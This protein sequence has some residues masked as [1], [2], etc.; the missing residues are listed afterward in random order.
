MTSSST[1][2]TRPRLTMGLLQGAVLYGLNQSNTLN[3]WPATEPQWFGPL[4]M[5]AVFLPLLG[6]SAWGRMTSRGWLTWMAVA[7]GIVAALA[8][9]DLWRMNPL[10]E[11]WR[12]SQGPSRFPSF[13]A[14]V[15]MSAGLFMAHCLVLAS[16]HDGRRVASY[17]TCFDQAWKLGI[18][19]FFSALFVGALWLMLYLGASL[20]GLIGLDFLQELLRK[21]WF[22]L[23]VSTFAL[24]WAL[25]LTDVKPEIVRGIRGLVLVLLSWILPV[26]AA[27]ATGFLLSLPFT[28]LGLL[29]ATR[30]ATSVLM[31]T[32]AALVVL[33]NTA[34]Q[35]GERSEQVNRA[36]RACAR[37]GCVL[38][39]PLVGLAVY[40]L[41]LRVAQ[42]GWS[43][44]RII[45]C[46]CQLVAAC[47][48]LGYAWAAVSRTGVWLAPIAWVNVRV[49]WVMLATLL[50][51]FSPV[52]DPSRL[53]VAD[54]LDRLRDGRITADQLD[55]R[56]L[57]FETGRHGLEALYLL[58]EGRVG[59]AQAA[60]AARGA[61]RALQMKRY[62]AVSERENR[63]DL[64]MDAKAV[65]TNIKAVWPQGA[66]LP[67]T[68]V[69]TAWHLESRQGAYGSGIPSCL[70]KL[71][72]SCEAVLLQMDD[73]PALE[74]LIIQRLPQ[75]VA[76][77]FDQAADQSWQVAATLP[78]HL[79]SCEDHVE[80]LREGRFDLVAPRY[81]D[82]KLGELRVPL[83]R[84]GVIGRDADG[85][86]PAGC[87]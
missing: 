42:H 18:Q 87:R 50:A 39:L 86:L 30:H 16:A 4:L 22:N 85:A 78:S 37:L 25:H 33:I 8:W 80:R 82:L 1:D 36:V 24:A 70:R 20:F 7:A 71:E 79:A 9:Y 61:Q 52:A 84:D 60:S 31:I 59:G 55:Y 57:R 66:Q 63:S 64:T 35:N 13:H 43:V 5:L 44:D 46:A 6:I 19:H 41:G 75:S 2:T 3:L 40:A 53:A 14:W 26:V 45:A 81:K 76:V 69:Q 27:L 74:V 12:V 47:Y 23:L 51:L 17:A 38:L 83:R 48:A 72:A 49:T 34:F 67:D 32:A 68:F 54:Q 73:D 29:W 21:S 28:G 15:F 77:L 56:Y 10:G 65:R 58:A 62:E 11:G